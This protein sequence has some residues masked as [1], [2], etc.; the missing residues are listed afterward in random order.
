MSDF[1]CR[2]CDADLPITDC[3]AAL[4]NVTICEQCG[5]GWRVCFD[6]SVDG[7]NWWWI[8]REESISTIP[9]R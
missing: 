2:E 1:Q 7:Q 3:W 5:S 4:G 8:E 6:E 9:R